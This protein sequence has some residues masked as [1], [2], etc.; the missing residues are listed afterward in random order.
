MNVEWNVPR[1]WEGASVYI[2]GGGY[3]LLGEKLELIH[4]K[5][6]IGVNTSFM[7]GDWVDVCW[8]GDTRWY[9]WNTVDLSEFGGLKACCCGALM[10]KPEVKVLKRGKSM[11]IDIRP[12]FVSWN[13]SSGSS[14]I[15]LA[16]HLGAKRIVLLG[17]DMKSN[18]RGEDNW[19]DLHKVKA[20]YNSYPRFLEAF[21]LIRKDAVDLGV[22]IINST[23]C[24]LIPEDIFPKIPLEE[25]VSEVQSSN[26]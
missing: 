2:L 10:D 15:N 6:V 14:A 16:V 17:F 3:S 1:M 4:D 25:I 9:D 12:N 26:S 8:F 7:L 18:D 22:E 20:H 11:G 24:S 21:P 5:R 13:R 23:M 19:H